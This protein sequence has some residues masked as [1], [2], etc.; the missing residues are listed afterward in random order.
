MTNEEAIALGA[1]CNFCPLN[2]SRIVPPKPASKKL[3]LVIVGEGPGRVE[4]NLGVPFMGMSG[5]VLDQQLRDNEIKRSECHITN[6]ALCRGES[7][8]DNERAAECCTPRLLREL[9]GLAPDVPI[10]LLGK[11]ATIAVLGLRSIMAGRGFIWRSKEIDSKK[12][13]DAYRKAAKLSG[14]KGEAE[15]ILRADT[16]AGRA[17]IPG[18]TVVPTLHPAFIL[19]ADTYHPIW[20]IDMAR[21]GRVVRGE[22]K[23]ENEGK[24]EVGGP[25]LLANMGPVVTCD[26]E[27]SGVDVMTCTI[28]CVGISDG[29]RDV[30]LWPWKPAWKKRLAKFL[31]SR[32]KVVF[33]NM[34]FDLTVLQN[35]DII[36]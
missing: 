1:H 3:R 26:L 15:A 13:K 24:H 6:T 32:E 9:S 12:I 31:G 11:A 16:T 19:R 7:D 17:G 20:R 23:L 5:K 34:N 33:H 22:A 29:A 8:K 35:N 2:G 28:L 25:E 4:E 27:T 36:W 21:M 10:L 30:V 18:R 14:K